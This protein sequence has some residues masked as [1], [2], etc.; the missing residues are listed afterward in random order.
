MSRRVIG[1]L[2]GA[3]VILGAVVGVRAWRQ[4]QVDEASQRAERAE[5]REERD[6]ARRG[7]LQRES[8]ALM[9][10]VLEG[11][12]LGMPLDEAR[13]ARPALAPE[14]SNRNPEPETTVIFE[15]S[16]PNGARAVYVFER[17]TDRLQ[18]VQVL[19]LLPSVNAVAPHLAAMNA[20]YGTPTGIYDCPR[21]GGVPTRRFTWQH[22]EITVADVFLVAGSRV[23]VTLYIAPNGIIERS[24]RTA[25]CRPVQSRSQLETFPA[26]SREQL[27][28]AQAP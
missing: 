2:L 27:E 19:S 10:D 20:Q 12:Y 25:A 24:L 7:R 22:G 1:W 23:S 5:A 16:F 14:L 15:E 4:H 8:Q 18:R 6:E 11:V 9:P 3:C 17:A 13:Q 21:T 28:A 26:A